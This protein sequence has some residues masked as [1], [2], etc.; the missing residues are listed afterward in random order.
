ME[1][2]YTDPGV[3]NETIV[4]QGLSYQT[5]EASIRR[6]LIESD[7]A[8]TEMRL[9][10]EKSTNKS[11]GF[12]FVTFYSL[13]H[14]IKWVKNNI[15]VILIDGVES[16]IE[17]AKPLSDDDWECALCGGVNF[18]KR[19]VCYRCKS[20]KELE[21]QEQIVNDGGQDI[22]NAPSQF[23]LLRGLD[24]Q[25]TAET[26]FKVINEMA[27]IKSV[28]LVKDRHSTAKKSWGFAFVD[29]ESVQAS[30]QIL[31]VIFDAKNPRP[32]YIEDQPI[33]IA[34]GHNGSFIPVNGCDRYTSFVRIENGNK[35]YFSYW[36]QGAS[37]VPYPLPEELQFEDPPVLDLPAKRNEKEPTKKK[38]VK[39]KTLSSKFSFQV[40]K[41]VEKQKELD[42]GDLNEYTEEELLLKLPA[43]EIVNEEYTDINRIACLLCRR[44][45]E[46]FPNLARHFQ[47]SRLHCQKMTILRLNQIQD[48]REILHRQVQQVEYP[49][50]KLTERPTMDGIKQ[51]NKGNQLLQKMGWKEGEGLGPSKEGILKPIKPTLVPKGAG[52]GSVKI[53][54]GKISKKNLLT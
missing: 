34:Y 26:I 4:L 45:F 17:Y 3:P 44:R 48:L 47:L 49:E 35:I 11:R 41:W 38:S 32:L 24:S 51:D 50:E 22:G 30:N 33:F 36:D 42:A 20:P 16:R 10:R 40:L 14:A 1:M 13:E 39:K 21:K 7:A 18:R 37:C 6:A 8:F 46:D 53:S 54:K 5:N 43:D 29:C 2:K 52:I 9:V 23:L 27:S 12:A 19:E 28:M 31:N 25:T 15:P